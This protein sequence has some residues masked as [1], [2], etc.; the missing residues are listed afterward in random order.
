MTDKTTSEDAQET[1]IWP[2]VAV[3]VVNWNGWR[4][5]LACLDCVKRLDYPDYLTIVVDNGSCDD[6]VERIRNWAR[7]NLAE[8]SFVPEYSRLSA[9]KGG[10]EWVERR[11]ERNSQE[12]RMIIV[13]NER[14]L[15][16][17]GGHNVAIHYALH[18]RHGA[19]YV[20]LLNNDA[21][22]EEACLGELV[23]AAAIADAGIVGAVVKGKSREEVLF[24]GRK[25][26][27]PFI[28][29]FFQPL[30]RPRGLAVATV[31]QFSTCLWVSGAAM[32]IRR[33]T[34]TDVFESTGRY[35][36]SRLF[37]YNEEVEFCINAQKL[38]YKTVCAKDAV[39]YH[40]AFSSS[41]GL[42]NPIAYYYI[43]RNHIILGNRL[44]PVPLRMLFLLRN[45]T[46]T[47]ARIVE[48]LISGRPESAR[49][50]LWALI[51]GYRGVGGKWAQHD[52]MIG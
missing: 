52:E 31:E 33:D 51:D 11:F 36:D 23:N 21:E 29:Q 20:F 46:V 35:L 7:E 48:N 50:I 37:L 2:L 25:E 42:Y 49:A 8:D 28:R 5:T 17:T 24:A 40:K 39:V 30:V 4:N 12:N 13:R 16:F 38:G 26:D 1:M 27:F 34:L 41:N 9:R 45:V 10:D 3:S 15:G 22:T 14:N 43:N 44:L 19:D 47:L 18:R 6:S 32:L